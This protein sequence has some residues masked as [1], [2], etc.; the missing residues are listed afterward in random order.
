MR[1][2]VFVGMGTAFLVLVRYGWAAAVVFVAV[3]APVAGLFLVHS[4]VRAAVA[5]VAVFICSDFPSG[6]AL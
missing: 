6:F 3:G 5:A 1:F 2:L 4:A